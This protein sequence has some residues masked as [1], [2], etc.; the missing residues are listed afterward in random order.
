[1][2]CRIK[3]Q[4]RRSAAT[5]VEM[6]AIISVFV[7][8]LFGIVEY[9]RLIW[10]QQLMINA[11]RE[12]ARYAVV[13]SADDNCVAASQ[14]R[15]REAM[16][17]AYDQGSNYEIN[18][19]KADDAGNNTGIPYDAK[20]GEVIMVEMECDYHPLL[21]NL[22]MMDATIRLKAKAPMTCEAN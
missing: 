14:A 19:F 2:R 13:H 1:M 5:V 8:I 11:S 20:F 15:S 10:F 9:C 16:S 22:L 7:L 12:G 21:P 17:A 4:T 3:S 18:V 6:A